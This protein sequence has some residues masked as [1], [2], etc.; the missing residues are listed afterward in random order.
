MF[1]K[2]IALVLALL[3]CI[4][5][6]QLPVSADKT[7]RGYI[8][9]IFNEGDGDRR[10]YSFLDLET[11]ETFLLEFKTDAPKQSSRLPVEIRA[12]K[13]KQKLIVKEILAHNNKFK[14]FYSTA[15]EAQGNQR[16]NVFIISDPSFPEP[17][18]QD[19]NFSEIQKKVF[20][21]ESYGE[22][23][24]DYLKDVSQ[25][26]MSIFG[27]IY[28]ATIPGACSD[29]KSFRK[30]IQELIEHYESLDPNVLNTQRVIIMTHPE[31]F[32]EVGIGGRATFGINS[33]RSE[34]DTLY[35][36]SVSQNYFPLQSVINH[37]FGHNIGLS[38]DNFN[39]CDGRIFTQD[40]PAMEYE[41]IF[42]IMGFERFANA[43]FNSI[44]K[45]D[46]EW[47]RPGEIVNLNANSEINQEFLLAPLNQNDS[48]LK[49]I[50]I[51]LGSGNFLHLEN[52]TPAGLEREYSWSY[53]CNFDGVILHLNKNDSVSSLNS[54]LI[55]PNLV[56]HTGELDFNGYLGVGSIK[57]D[58][59]LNQ[60]YREANSALL[61]FFDVPNQNMRIVHLGNEGNEIKLAILANT[62]IESDLEFTII[63]QQSSPESKTF[64]FSTSLNPNDVKRYIWDFRDGT[65]SEELSPNHSFD[66]R[67]G[68]H[69]I[70]LT[71]VD[72][73][74][75][76]KEQ[77][78]VINIP[79][80]APNVD[81]SYSPETPSINQN[82]RFESAASDLDGSIASN[83][84]DFGDGTIT[85][86]HT[87]RFSECGNYNVKLT[88]TD[89]LGASNSIVKQ[90]FIAGDGCS[91]KVFSYFVSPDVYIDT[92][93]NF[94]GFFTNIQYIVDIYSIDST[95]N[96]DSI[97]EFDF[98]NDGIYEERSDY[99]GVYKTF[100]RPGTYTI[101]FR[102]NNG[103]DEIINIKRTINVE[104]NISFDLDAN[105]IS[106]VEPNSISASSSP[107]V[108]NFNI[109]NHA[110]LNYQTLL[111]IPK[112]FRKFIKF[113]GTKKKNLKF[114][115]S[116]ANDSYSVS[117]KLAPYRKI[118]R[119]LQPDENGNLSLTIKML[120]RST[121]DSYYRYSN[122]SDIIIN[123]TEEPIE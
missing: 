72:S 73:Q 40:C 106:A 121:K 18:S 86:S 6:Y 82:I 27:D 11:R 70:G 58:S 4:H 7:Y 101:N 103:P 108:M 123:I 120:T 75:K 50:R 117:L 60:G 44:N 38:H 21:N 37:E 3:S 49:A 62:E 115:M 104:D 67:S 81:F 55:D 111:R 87:H 33:Y 61:E 100:S 16:V 122:T 17:L 90:V 95:V 5:L 35:Q 88:A 25:N 8:N 56:D 29:D 83:E 14:L 74:N 34:S 69:T 57:T 80:I 109:K 89:N 112:K 54:L 24:N 94:P 65:K 110:P 119:R 116:E 51:D 46:L 77:T 15:A 47:F 28:E 97:L 98:D 20:G 23:L 113:A 48:S 52:R 118:I 22:S 105:S 91:D 99:R 13:K 2:N 102:V 10:E 41:G 63:A 53:K 1:F 12:K 59:Y 79:N 9:I 66:T 32:G 36:F 107:K 19:H 71:I 78:L 64:N 31:C 84:W 30:L 68:P 26:K 93:I 76:S 92:D 42:N 96:Y 45:N 39:S 43:S 114:K 85:N